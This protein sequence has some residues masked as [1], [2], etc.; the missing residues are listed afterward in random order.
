M[1]NSLEMHW[2][3]NPNAPLIPYS[4]HFGEEANFVGD[5]IAMI[6]YGIVI[7]LFFQCVGAVL[8]GRARRSIRLVLVAHTVAMFFFLTVSIAMGM[9]LQSISWINNREFND[10][11]FPGPLGYKAQFHSITRSIPG[12]TF[13]LNQ[14]LADGLLL[15]R[16]CVVYSTNYWVIAFPGLVYIASLVMGLMDMVWAVKTGNLY[17]PFDVDTTYLS[18][19]LFLNVLLTLMIVVRLVLHSRQIQSAM[20]VAATPVRLYKALITLL[21]ESC[22]LYAISFAIFLA[23]SIANNRIVKAF[24]PILNVIQVLAP[25][26]IIQRVANQRTVTRD[27]APQS[28]SSIRFL[29][30]RE[31][32]DST[33]TFLDAS[34]TGPTER[35]GE[36]AGGHEARAKT[37]SEVPL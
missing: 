28:I 33:R 13:Q 35:D 6:L 1:P 26:L 17:L 32:A 34:A 27:A 18:I 11:P 24:W 30:R 36:A 22:A 7:V 20:G 29:D 23:T 8:A 37:P 9:N 10:P 15:Y 5:F 4:L 21:V 31:F 3:N 14:W 25:F 16:C 2:S 19:S 12:T